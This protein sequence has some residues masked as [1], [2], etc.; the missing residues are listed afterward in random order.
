MLSDSVD[1]PNATGSQRTG[2]SGVTRYACPH[3]GGANGY[4]AKVD[5]EARP[6][7]DHETGE[8]VFVRGNVRSILACPDCG[9]ETDDF[10]G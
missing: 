3:C 5:L 1:H 8:V 9:R 6:M 2:R 7:Q 4:V 10:A